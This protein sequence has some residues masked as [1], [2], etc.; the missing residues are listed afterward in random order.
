MID[1][2]TKLKSSLLGVA[3][4]TVTAT[5][6]RYIYY[7]VYLSRNIMN[8][9]LAKSVYRF[10]VNI[11]LY[12]GTSLVGRRVIGALHID[13]FAVWAMY[14][15]VFGVGGVAIVYCINRLLFPED[16]KGIL[17]M[18]KAFLKRKMKIQK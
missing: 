3:I 9:P 17:K 4:G 13:G 15:C 7:V 14:A 6:F 16:T 18:M 8:R 11:V 2:N 5:L 10:V 1:E 12:L